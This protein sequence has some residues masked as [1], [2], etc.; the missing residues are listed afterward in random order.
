MATL[1]EFPEVIERARYGFRGT[2][3]GF[4]ALRLKGAELAGENGF[5][6][7][8]EKSL[9]FFS[10]SP[11][12]ALGYALTAGEKAEKQ[13]DSFE[14]WGVKSYGPIVQLI[15]LKNYKNRIR[16][17]CEWGNLFEG[18][19]V[20]DINVSDIKIMGEQDVDNLEVY[21]REMNS[22]RFLLS[23]SERFLENIKKYYRRNGD[24]LFRN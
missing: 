1:D 18:E 4:Y 3:R 15:D 6:K 21:L 5:Y 24:S 8:S 11:V 14:R 22:E 13:K 17:G 9:T 20:G 23:S 10:L 7:A 2:D 16:P 12:V 19:V